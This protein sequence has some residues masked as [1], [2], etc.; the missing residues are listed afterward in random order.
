MVSS[1]GHDEDPRLAR[2]LAALHQYVGGR[3]P[4]RPTDRF[5]DDLG[6]DSVEFLEFVSIVTNDEWERLE[7]DVDWLGIQTAADLYRVLLNTD[8]LTL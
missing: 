4:V 7:D 2:F 5:V 1:G 6:L 3:R 8:L